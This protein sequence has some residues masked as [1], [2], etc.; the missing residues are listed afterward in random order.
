MDIEPYIRHIDNKRVYEIL[1]S[2]KISF[3]D[4]EIFV[5]KLIN[6]Y[7]LSKKD[8]FIEEINRLEGD[9]QISFSRDK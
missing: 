3:F 4:L 1:I 5:N 8:I 2:Q 6:K 9:I 7:R